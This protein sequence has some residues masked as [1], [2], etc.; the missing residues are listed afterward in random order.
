[1]SGINRIDS[2]STLPLSTN[3]SVN[4]QTPD[5]SFGKRINA[6]LDAATGIVGSGL[7]IAGS[8]FVGG[9][10]IV[11]A[12]VSSVRM[13]NHQSSGANH[14]AWGGG[15]GAV[16]AAYAGFASN[17][18][19]T[20]VPSAAGS[21]TTGLGLP[22]TGSASSTGVGTASANIDLDTQH[23]QNMELLGIQSALQREN[24]VFSSLSNAMKTRHDT[25]KN[26]ISNLR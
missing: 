19:N 20:T 15:G 12:A 6:G 16:N 23:K 24:L 17:A 14:N 2:G 1:M 10:A 18:I 9:P 21:A 22:S 3:F 5:M 4:R 13:A 11:S 7:G 26:S 25:A 8:A